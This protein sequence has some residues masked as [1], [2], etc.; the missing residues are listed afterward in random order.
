M[1]DFLGKLS[2]ISVLSTETTLPIAKL[3]A[4]V[5][6]LMVGDDISLKSSIVSPV[7]YEKQM[8]KLLYNKTK[9]FKGSEELKLSFT[10]FQDKLSNLDKIS[11]IWALYKST[12]K[13]LGKVSF[14][15]PEC[16]EKFTREV[17]LDELIH[18][19][20]FHPWD[21]DVPFNE[22]GYYVLVPSESVVYGVKLKLPSVRDHLKLLSLV[23]SYE[24]NENINNLGAIFTKPLQLTLITG[25]IALFKK[26]EDEGILKEIKERKAPVS[27]L[28]DKLEF[29]T[30]T[31]STQEI[32][33]AYEKHISYD[34][35]DQILALYDE[36]FKDYIIKYYTN[37]TCPACNHSWTHDIDIELQFL[38]RAIFGP[39][40]TEE[41]L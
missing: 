5:S 19:D 25:N 9:L 34:V 41:G 33:I 14:I 23:P 24:L 40:S 8:L 31:D 35:G 15:C 29:I 10:E 16:E 13:T 30:E 22:Y 37:I 36:H 4:V 7:N 38:R 27:E 20:T 1:S 21:K 32:L 11:L 28:V 12:Y 6:P 17:T 39:A 3:G 2:E 18:P 26:P